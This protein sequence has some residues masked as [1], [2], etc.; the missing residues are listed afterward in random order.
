METKDNYFP[1][2]P[3]DTPSQREANKF[4]REEAR[5][6]HVIGDG[7]LVNHLCAIALKRVA[8][9]QSD[10]KLHLGIEETFWAIA[11]ALY[12]L[13][14]EYML[15]RVGDILKVFKEATADRTD[16]SKIVERVVYLV[17][18]PLEPVDGSAEELL[19]VG[20]NWL[21]DECRIE[22]LAVVTLAIELV[23]QRDSDNKHWIK[24]L[25][26]WQARCSAEF[27]ND[28]ND[29]HSRLLLQ[30]GLVFPE[31]FEG[32]LKSSDP[33][34]ST[35]EA[36]FYKGWKQYLN[37]QWEEMNKTLSSVVP[38]IPYDSPRFLA[39]CGLQR[40][41]WSLS[42]QDSSGIIATRWQLKAS[43][44]GPSAFREIRRTTFGQRLGEF[45]RKQRGKADLYPF[46]HTFRLGLLDQVASLREWD[47]WAWNLAAGQLA[48][49]NI[50]F[51]TKIPDEH[52]FAVEGLRLAIQSRTFDQDDLVLK[53]RILALDFA[54]VEERTRLVKSMLR[55][56]PVE[57]FKVLQMLESLSDAIPENSL[58]AVADWCADYVQFQRKRPGWTVHPLSLWGQ[59]LPYVENASHI[60]RR[61]HPAVM[62]SADHPGVWR[63]DKQGMV[64]EFLIRAPFDLAVEVGEKMMRMAMEDH[65]TDSARWGL[66][67]NAVL[68][69]QDPSFTMTF[70]QRLIETARTEYAKFHLPL[71]ENPE[72]T[73][74]ELDAARLHAWC[75]E[76]I[77][78][79]V[80]VVVGRK[81]GDPIGFGPGV[82]LDTIEKVKWAEGDV[83][84]VTQLIKSIDSAQLIECSEVE[85]FLYY[86]A[87]MVSRGPQVVADVLQEALLRWIHTPP[88]CGDSMGGFV[89]GPAAQDRVMSALVYLA[90]GTVLRKR[91]APD[92]SLTLWVKLNGFSCPTHV[93]ANMIFLGAVLGADLPGIPGIDMMSTVQLLLLRAWQAPGVAEVENEELARALRQI[94]ELMNPVNTWSIYTAESLESARVFF[95]SLAQV[96]PHM[97]KYPNPDVR[98]AAASILRLWVEQGSMP[99][100]L[101]GTLAQFQQDARA[102]VRFETRAH[103]S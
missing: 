83:Q 62:A 54:P 7:F 70:K 24:L 65:P 74:D 50:A 85:E 19:G 66:M 100:E 82:G 53:N 39:L 69:R 95:N 98:A 51:A 77:L 61:L 102:R 67:F 13:I 81:R 5:R 17:R 22:G 16:L 36:S 40:L 71:L 46:L 72:L 29:L 3:A 38:F 90:A 32:S 56:R 31:R 47:A 88:S 68:G 35:V 91:G 37:C 103:D 96:I 80:E 6:A 52:G 41:D 94:A 25:R 60:C 34:W 76:E 18:N 79:R 42:P 97:G 20:L 59:I 86:C 9:V 93:I 27:K 2:E 10:G 33:F 55:A 49:A 64:T 63:T 48:Q 58:L 57:S 11:F 30:T 43:S 26:Q 87:A 73:L 8:R 12:W 45:W 28:L 75:K 4:L 99:S 89:V 92:E 15:D 1:D 78:R 23:W 84:I 101:E 21:D 44:G 14:A